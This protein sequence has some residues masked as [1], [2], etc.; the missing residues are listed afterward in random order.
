MTEDR[1]DPPEA[2]HYRTLMVENQL[3]G[4]DIRDPAVLSAMG[5]VPRHLFATFPSFQ[6][7]Y[8][9]S[10]FSI[11]CHQTISQPYMVAF[12]TQE[13]AIQRDHKILEVGTGSGYQTAVLCELSDN[14]YSVERL[15][16]LAEETAGLLKRLGYRP[17]KLVVG[18]GSQGLADE[19]PFDRI[20]VT[21]AAPSQPETLF[22]QL[23]PDGGVILFPVDIQ[24]PYQ[25]LRKVIRTGENHFETFSLGEVRFVPLV[26]D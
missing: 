1:I 26:V 7:A 6:E 3:K 5:D 17:R 24:A 19:A 8:A 25:E 22:K 9:D 4:R 16:Q 21:A 20:L 13:L 23:R 15:P 2:I 14:V 18:D 10:A 12:M 11:P